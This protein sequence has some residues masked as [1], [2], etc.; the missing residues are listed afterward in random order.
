[1]HAGEVPDKMQASLTGMQGGCQASSPLAVLQPELCV[2]SI[3]S[4]LASAE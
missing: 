1:M 3:A 2:R 4:R